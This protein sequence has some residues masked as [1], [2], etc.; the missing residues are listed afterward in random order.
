MPWSGTLAKTTSRTKQKATTKGATTADGNR[1]P[2]PG[3]V[4]R[5]WWAAPLTGVPSWAPQPRQNR[6]SSVPIDLPQRGTR[7]WES[8]KELIAE[9]AATMEDTEVPS[10]A[11]PPTTEPRVFKRPSRVP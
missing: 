2:L 6:W 4:E 5:D 7:S 3:L 9:T 8:H 10:V 11:T 1:L